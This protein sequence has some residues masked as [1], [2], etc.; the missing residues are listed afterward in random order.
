MLPMAIATAALSLKLPIVWAPI[1]ARGRF[2][3]LLAT[4]A[5]IGSVLGMLL[6]SEV[7]FVTALQSSCTSPILGCSN[8][9]AMNLA[10]S[11]ALAGA[12]LG[13]AL[14]LAVGAAIA[15]VP[16]RAPAQVDPR[17]PTVP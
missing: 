4:G 9:G 16:P 15:A 14:G 10:E 3:A 2:A 5:A 13:G 12:W 8:G 6:V 1:S 11:A 17:A 7:A